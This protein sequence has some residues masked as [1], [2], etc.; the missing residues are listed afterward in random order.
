M[1]RLNAVLHLFCALLTAILYVVALTQRARSRA[2]VFSRLLLMAAFVMMS[3][4]GVALLLFADKGVVF[5]ILEACSFAAYY[6]LLGMLTKYLCIVCGADD[7]FYRGITFVCYG[8]CGTG[9]I[10]WIVYLLRK[11][12]DAEA[13]DDEAE[14]DDVPELAE[15]EL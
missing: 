8:L 10:L 13:D 12:E 5:N 14:E 11:T 15:D 4:H 2:T 9:M 6:V 3:C 1:G 7:T